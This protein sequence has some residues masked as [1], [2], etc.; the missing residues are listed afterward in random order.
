MVTNE[1]YFS[2]RMIDVWPQTKILCYEKLK[3]WTLAILRYATKRFFILTGI[4]KN[5]IYENIQTLKKETLK[6][7]QSLLFL[8][9]EKIFNKH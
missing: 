3:Y 6:L 1:K 9:F 2:R 8:L 7:D 5:I 4:T